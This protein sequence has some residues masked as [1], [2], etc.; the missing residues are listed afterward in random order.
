[1]EIYARELAWALAG[2]EDVE[3]VL[4][5]NRLL[6]ENWPDVERIVMPVDPRRR[7]EWVLGDQFHAPRA[8]ARVRADVVHSLASTASRGR[9]RA[10]A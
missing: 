6:A 3:L 4:L 7:V 1:M 5:E 2:R 8:A 10:G 9:K